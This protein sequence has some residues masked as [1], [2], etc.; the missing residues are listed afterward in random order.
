MRNKT[1]DIAKGLGILFVVLGHNWI[2]FTGSGELYN[3]IYSFQLLLFFYLSGIFHNQN[4]P[5]A[6]LA[7]RKADALLKPY[8]VV[9]LV[10]GIVKSIYTG[11]TSL[12]Y[13][14]GI[15]YANGNTIDWT[16]LWFLPHLFAVVIFDW[17]IIKTCADIIK[18][19][20]V[21]WFLVALFLLIGGLP[22][23]LFWLRPLPALGFSSHPLL[24]GMT[25]EGLPFNLDIILIPSAYFLLGHLTSEKALQ[26]KPDPILLI[27]AFVTFIGLHYF[28]NETMDLNYRRYGNVIICALQTLTATYVVLSLASMINGWSP[29]RTIF[30][31]IGEASLIILLFHA[32]LQDSIYAALQGSYSYHPVRHGLMAF[33]GSVAGS[34][35]IYEIIG[36]TKW[37]CALIMP[38]PHYTTKKA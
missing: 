19:P 38:L 14:L 33:L 28:F 16:P 36:R 15:L 4:R 29:S 26:F 1:I 13:F 5:L 10:V 27:T 32:P 31:Y 12:L 24:S 7:A 17:V 25:L 9:L 30:S 23:R 21:L 2:T 22:M 8:F 34:L 11:K 37:L 18:R 6:S 35:L 3:V 20:E